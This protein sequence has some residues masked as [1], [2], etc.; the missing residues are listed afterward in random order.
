MSF[1]CNAVESWSFP[2]VQ[3][4]YAACEGDRLEF[5]FPLHEVRVRASQSAML[6]AEEVR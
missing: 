3:L 1:D 2:R 4:I 6:L 5:H